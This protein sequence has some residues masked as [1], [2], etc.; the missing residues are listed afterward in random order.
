MGGGAWG[1]GMQTETG[2]RRREFIANIYCVTIK[3]F[4]INHMNELVENQAFVGGCGGARRKESGEKEKKG[5]G[6][7][8]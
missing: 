8:R 3:Q 6:K 5:R 2:K 1:D 7:K 4:T